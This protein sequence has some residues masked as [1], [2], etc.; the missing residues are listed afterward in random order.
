MAES[1]ELS[2]RQLTALDAVYHATSDNPATAKMVAEAIEPGSDA[3]G[4][5]QTLRRMPEFVTRQEDGTYK[6]TRKG[7]NL[8]QKSHAAG[9]SE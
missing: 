8:V 5:A 9:E 1:V 4:A 3:R 6:L 2:P 7:K